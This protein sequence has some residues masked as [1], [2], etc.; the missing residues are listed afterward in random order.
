VDALAATKPVARLAH[1]HDVSRKFVYQQ[2]DKA[3]RVLA[4][5]FTP[6]LGRTQRVLCTVPVTKTLL[7]QMVLGLVLI[8][9]SSFRGVVEF[10][11]DILDCPLSLGSVANIVRSAVAPAR[12]RNEAQDL[13][14]V[15][16]G[17]LD[18]IYQSLQPVLVGVD[19]YSTYCYLLSQ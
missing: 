19:V 6:A 12:A 7:R 9:H 5:A 8:C 15:R 11:R 13:A 17:A 10:L 14:A 1:E 4:D 2:A 16:H 3:Q 18:E